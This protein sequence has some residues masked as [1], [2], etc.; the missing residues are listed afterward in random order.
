MTGDDGTQGS[1]EMLGT[2]SLEAGPCS[3]SPLSAC[4]ATRHQGLSEE[5]TNRSRKLLDKGS[6]LI[7]FLAS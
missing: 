2:M 6:V 4:G 5:D 7:N 1:A 3:Q